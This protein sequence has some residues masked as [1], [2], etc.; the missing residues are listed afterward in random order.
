MDAVYV[1]ACA[2]LNL[3]L[4]ITGKRDDG[5]HLLRSVMQSIDLFDYVK[6]QKG[7]TLSVC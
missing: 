2:K 6:V 4:D 5:Y 1:K 7:E 3:F